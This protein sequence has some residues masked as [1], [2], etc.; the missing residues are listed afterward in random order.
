[1]AIVLRNAILAD[2]DPIH[3]EAGD[4]RIESS[5]IVERGKVTSVAG[6]EEFDCRGA[7]VL[8]GMVNGHTH[9]YSAL[10]VGMPAPPRIPQNFYEILEL[11]W[12]RLDRG[13]GRCVKRNVRED[14]GDRCTRCG[15][16]TLIDHHASPNA[17]DGSLDAIERGINSVGLRGVLCYEVTD[18]NGVKGREA[19][20]EENRRYIV[21]TQ[22]LRNGIFAGLSGAHASFTMDDVSLV[23]VSHWADEFSTGGAHSC[24]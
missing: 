7:V 17:I 14:R 1:M 22:K 4:V 9:L 13:A 5:R 3:V 2:I 24:R 16:T 8:P 6:D 18:R 21:K 11:V 23:G 20:L 19:G 12:W 15:T 10:A